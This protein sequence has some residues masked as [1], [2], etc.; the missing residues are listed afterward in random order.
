MSAALSDL[1]SVVAT[2]AGLPEV[3]ALRVTVGTDHVRAGHW[4]VPV[5]EVSVHADGYA[6]AVRVAQA[7]GLPEVEARVIDSDVCGRLRWRT[8]AGWA[9]AVTRSVPVSVS[10]TAAEPATAGAVA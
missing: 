5:V 3:E 9:T 7:W 2:V 10:V 1:A 6:D 4:Y 8:W